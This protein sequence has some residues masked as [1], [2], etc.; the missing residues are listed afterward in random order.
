MADETA[1][2]ARLMKVAEAVVEEFDRQGVA[3]V[4]ASLNF[5]PVAL[6]RAVIKAADGDV[7]QFPGGHRS[8]EIQRL[9]A[10]DYTEPG[11]GQSI[12]PGLRRQWAMRRMLKLAAIPV[13]L[14]DFGATMLRTR[15]L[16]NRKMPSETPFRRQPPGRLI[17]KTTKT[18][19]WMPIRRAG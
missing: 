1:E 19:I 12:D 2:T 13:A 17:P 14:I 10:A 9:A 16:R 11:H 4:L 3:D 18:G 5:D 6:A 15:P 7:I 8:H